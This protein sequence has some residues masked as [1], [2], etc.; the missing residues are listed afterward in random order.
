MTET[1]AR[2]IVAMNCFT[3]YICLFM[4]EVVIDDIYIY[5]H[6]Y[7]IYIHI[8]CMYIR[9]ALVPTQTPVQWVPYLCR[10]KAAVAWR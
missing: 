6:I 4:Y 2:L 1:C 9:P 10:G 5:I 8:I 3:K 7:I